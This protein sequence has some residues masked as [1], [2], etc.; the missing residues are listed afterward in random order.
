[1]RKH[2]RTNA[3]THTPL[4]LAAKRRTQRQ[5][6]QSEVCYNGFEK[7]Q[8]FFHKEILYKQNKVNE[9]NDRFINWVL[10]YAPCHFV[11]F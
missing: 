1:M 5:P 2:T 9:S 11:A 10:Q 4:F 7:K 6:T 8:N 3:H